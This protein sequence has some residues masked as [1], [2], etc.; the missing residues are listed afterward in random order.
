MDNN[1]FI[2]PKLATNEI[3]ALLHELDVNI[4]EEDLLKPT[5]HRMY[6]VYERFTDWLMGASREQ[7]DGCVNAAAEC[8]DNFEIH[9]DALG[10]MSFYS[11]LARLVQECQVDDFSLRDIVKPESARVH[12]ILSNILNFAKFREERQSILE[13]YAIKAE[14]NHDRLDRLKFEN[15]DLEEKLTSLR[16]QKLEEE[17]LTKAAKETN[18]HLTEDLRALKRAQTEMSHDIDRLKQEKSILTD[19]LANEQFLS[20]STKQEVAKVRSR[21]VQSPRKLKQAI[22]EMGASL[23]TDK[24]SV[25]SLEKRSRE[26]QAKVE[27]MGFV[28]QDLQACLRLME[29]C[30]T[31]MHRVEE[32]RKKVARQ[33]ESVEQKQIE[34]REVEV[35]EQQLA[36]QLN[37]AEDKLSR[38]RRQAEAKREA[39]QKKMSEIQTDYATVTAERQMRSKEMEK[40]KANIEYVEQKMA[41]LRSQNDNEMRNVQL[42]YAKL[43]SHISLYFGEM[44][45]AMAIKV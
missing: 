36:R 10:L 33:N 6:Y 16:A 42:E 19:R 27:A 34:V 3:V 28:E 20:V 1:L 4:T 29:E 23:A 32:A 31:E 25:S 43:Q 45:Q 22:V 12:K 24:T 8:I 35:K 2:V 7:F 17:P 44:E 9:R 30:E 13:K 38:A 18:H 5:P 14:S 40:K 37:N 15:E 26:L 39:A 11:Q 21:V 41:D